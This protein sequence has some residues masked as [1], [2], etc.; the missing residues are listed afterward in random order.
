M[1]G[2]AS[3]AGVLCSQYY[4]KKDIEKLRIITMMLLKIAMGIGLLFVLALI[5]LPEQI[6]WCFTPE[7]VV[8]EQAQPICGQLPFRICSTVSQLRS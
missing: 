5:F 8:I 4:G 2:L 3:G 6:M 1:G 7:K